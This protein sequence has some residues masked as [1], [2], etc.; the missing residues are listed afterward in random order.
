MMI[1]NKYLKQLKRHLAKT[2]IGRRLTSEEL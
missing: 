1:I 2:S